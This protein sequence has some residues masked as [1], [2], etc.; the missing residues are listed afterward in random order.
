MAVCHTVQVG[1]NYNEDEDKADEENNLSNI[2]SDV[3]EVFQN[4]LEETL[5]TE[6]ESEHETELGQRNNLNGVEIQALNADRPFSDL[7]HRRSSKALYNRPLSLTENVPSH[8]SA[9]SNQHV[10]FDID[11]LKNWSQNSVVFKK[12]VSYNVPD[13][14]SR[15]GHRRTQ[16]SVPY[17]NSSKNDFDSNC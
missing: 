5:V 14:C 8:N 15:N 9:N 6:D 1:G 17:V 16:S 11:D 12:T 3:P 4:I 10:R 2:Y 13:V 7:V